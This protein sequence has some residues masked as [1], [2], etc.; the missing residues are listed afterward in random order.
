MMKENCP[1]FPGL[2]ELS[3][4]LVEDKMA[5]NSAKRVL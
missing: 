3:P 2:D 5:T 1:W 4:I